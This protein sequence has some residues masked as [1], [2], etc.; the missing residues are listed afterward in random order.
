[1]VDYIIAGKKAHPISGITFTIDK[2]ILAKNILIHGKPLEKERVYD[3]SGG[4]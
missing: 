2:N 1:M 4:L 3:V